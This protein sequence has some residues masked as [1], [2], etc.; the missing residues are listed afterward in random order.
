LKVKA[1]IDAID[2]LEINGKAELV[3]GMVDSS[4]AVK[5]ISKR[6]I[7]DSQGKIGVFFIPDGTVIQCAERTIQEFTGLS[8]GN[9]ELDH[10]MSDHSPFVDGQKFF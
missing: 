7:P 6:N 5:S 4:V 3:Y 2:L 9:A 10:L 1:L 8:G